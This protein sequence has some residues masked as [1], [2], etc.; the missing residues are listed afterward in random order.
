MI[1]KQDDIEIKS[2]LGIGHLRWVLSI[3]DD[4]C[5]ANNLQRKYGFQFNYLPALTKEEEE[6]EIVKQVEAIQLLDWL[7]LWDVCTQHLILGNVDRTTLFKLPPSWTFE[8]CLGFIGCQFNNDNENYIEQLKV[9][10]NG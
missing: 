5:I 1:I 10:N 3:Y 4:Y 7:R 9:R 2:G 8:N 6:A